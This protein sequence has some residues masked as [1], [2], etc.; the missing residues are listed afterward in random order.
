MFL[1]E[2]RPHTR[3]NHVPTRRPAAFRPAVSLTEDGEAYTLTLELPGV[4]PEAIEV[5]LLSG[6]LTIKGEKTLPT[7][8]ED[9][10]VHVQERLAGGFERTVKFPMA[11][12]H[13]GVTAHAAH[14][15]LTVRVAKAKEALPRTIKVTG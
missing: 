11:V 13:D 14:G 5:T 15:V 1:H 8:G 3:A 6:E 12:A 2:L 7:P 10:N 9:V 4:A